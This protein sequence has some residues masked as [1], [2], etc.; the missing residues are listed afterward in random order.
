MKKIERHII[1]VVEEIR[2][3]QEGFLHRIIGDSILEF[4]YTLDIVDDY[5]DQTGARSVE[6]TTLR[7]SEVSYYDGN[8]G[9]DIEH[10]DEAWLRAEL[11]F[12]LN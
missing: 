5:D 4:S 8:S 2:A 6:E 3:K 1:S 11:L 7:L 9:Q 12:F 10:F